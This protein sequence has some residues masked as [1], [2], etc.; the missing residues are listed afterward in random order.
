[1][2]LNIPETDGKRVV[3]VGGGFGGLQLVKKLSRSPYQV[4]L[5]DRNNFH[6]FQPLLYQ[7]A[8]AAIN[9]GD[10]AFPFRKLFRG[11]KNVFFRMAEVRQ[12]DPGENTVYTDRGELRYDYLVLASGSTTNYFGMEH[13]EAESYPM[14]EVSEALT[15]RNRILLH[16]EKSV[17]LPPSELKRSMLNIVIVGGGATGVELAGAFAEM[18]NNIMPEDYPEY[19]RNDI[20]IYLIEGAPKLLG[21]M[22]ERTS[23]KTLELLE[24]CGVKVMLDS[25]VV[26]Y[27][28]DRVVLKDGRTIPTHNLIWTSGVTVKLPAGLEKYE[29]GKGGRLVT[30]MYFRVKG[31]DNIFAVGDCSI[32][33]E[34]PGNPNGYPQLARVAMEQ[35]AHLGRNL[36]RLARG[37]LP[38]RF[39]YR[40]YPVLATV[41]RNHAF[42]EYKK[43]WLGG[44]FAWLAWAGIHLFLM[45]GVK[46]KLNVFMGWVWNY[47]TF[48][49]PTRVVIIPHGIAARPDPLMQPD[50]V[51]PAASNPLP[52]ASEKPALPD[53][54]VSPGIVKPSDTGRA[55]PKDD[56]DGKTRPRNGQKKTADQK[57]ATPKKK[58]PV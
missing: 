23:R 37:K 54:A 1:M 31:A 22:Q 52:V 7:V 19:H 20:R 39:E 2:T 15:I 36:R 8:T 30:D 46:N 51:L 5:I 42:A 6:M 53:A 55:V 11:R 58:V 47:L 17:E 44:F 21:N 3:V 4:V 50:R 35:A 26:D 18:K 41:G 57:S 28:G 49:L 14:K 16:I 34:D 12:V 29:K 48:D 43:L 32:Q 9:P 38:E 13:I 45:L 24:R 33:T 56:P 10:I 27:S 25:T 40:Q